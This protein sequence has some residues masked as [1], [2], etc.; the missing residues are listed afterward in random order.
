MCCFVYKMS[1]HGA[2]DTQ[3][4]WATGGRQGLSPAYDK[5]KAYLSRGC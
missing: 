5:S 1:S 2:T 3:S 4:I